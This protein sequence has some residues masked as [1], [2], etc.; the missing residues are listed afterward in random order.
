MIPEQAEPLM[1]R[2]ATALALT[3]AGFPLAAATLATLATRGGGPPFRRF[4]SRALYRADEGL[5]WANS[6]LSKAVSST[7][8]LPSRKPLRQ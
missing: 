4:G 1:T 3:G 7:S 2:K 6:R 5:D 8:E